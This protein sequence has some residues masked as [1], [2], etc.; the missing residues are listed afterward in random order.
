[1]FFY[2]QALFC[3]FI[4]LSKIS[5]TEENVIASDDAYNL[6]LKGRVEW[7]K[8]ARD[9]HGWHVDFSH[10]TFR[11]GASFSEFIFPGKAYFRGAEFSGKSYFSEAQFTGEVH[12]ENAVFLAVAY[13]IGYEFF[14]NTS[15]PSF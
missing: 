12:F 7:N 2:E 14:D 1:M 4:T 9:N 11:K 10:R 3:I 8:W 5:N 13:F 15:T 6:Y